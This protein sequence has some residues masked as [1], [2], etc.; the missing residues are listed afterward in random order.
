MTY[1]RVGTA[2]ITTTATGAATVYTTETLNGHLSAM[3]V[4]ATGTTSTADIVVTG[5]TSGVAIL[6]KANITK[7]TST[8]FYPRSPAHTVAA[9]AT[10]SAV[11]LPMVPITDERIKVVMTGGGNAQGY[12]LKFYVT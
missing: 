12:T 4:T 3:K 7:A 10:T 11:V 1:V 5:E 2:T 8:W 9:G 6:T